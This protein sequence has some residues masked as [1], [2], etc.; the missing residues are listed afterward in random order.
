MDSTFED[1]FNKVGFQNFMPSCVNDISL[2]I[3]SQFESQFDTPGATV[4][5]LPFGPSSKAGYVIL[6]APKEN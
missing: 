1:T 4:T 6:K 3:E 5:L 2:P